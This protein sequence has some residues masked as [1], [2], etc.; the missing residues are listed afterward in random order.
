M[1][2]K[3]KG[4]SNV[5]DEYWL[6]QTYN[7]EILSDLKKKKSKIKIFFLMHLIELFR[8]KFLKHPGRTQ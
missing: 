1:I 5:I 6:L 2:K 8:N 7:L 3:R 4:K